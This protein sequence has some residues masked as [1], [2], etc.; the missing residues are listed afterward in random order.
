MAAGELPDELAAWVSSTAGGPVV[1]S[2]RHLAGASRQAW[3][4]D[5][6]NDGERLGLFLLRDQAG[7]RGGSARDAAVLRALADTPVPVPGVHGHDP[8]L[9][10]L[11]L[12]RVPGRGDFPAVDHEDEREPTARHLMELTAALH[13]VDPA[14]LAIEHL[15]DPAG[16]GPHAEAQLAGVERFA[17]MAGDGLDPLFRFALAW[18]RRNVPDGGGRTSLVHSDMGPGNFLAAGGRVTA[19]LD[20]EVAHWGDPMEDLAAVAVRDMATPVGHLPTRFAEYAAAGGPPVDLAAVAWYRI[21]VLTRNPMLIGFGL[22]RDDAAVDRVQMTMYRTML[23]RACALALCD[24]VGVARPEEPAFADPAGPPT[25]E[26]RLVAHARRDQRS[27]VLPALTDGF[28]ASR[29]AAVAGV[30]GAVEHRLRFGA[31]REERDLADLAVLLGR[32]PADIPQ[33]LASLAA[34]VDDP[35]REQG[36]AAFLARHLLR[37]G[38]LLA[39]ILGDLTERYPQPLEDQ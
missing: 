1:S 15:G 38:M 9:A 34:L 13:R 26:Q 5:V 4:V 10:A 12:E 27:T 16:V 35:G 36:L 31:E 2:R 19:I 33:G 22:A 8:E 20:W 18:L 30:L 17:A 28:A 25:D 14:S 29:G 21:L 37:E 3:S 32:R 39:P 11:L 23:M 6:D 24:V 7:G